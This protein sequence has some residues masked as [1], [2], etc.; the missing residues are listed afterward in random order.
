MPLTAWPLLSPQRCPGRFLPQSL[1]T[2][3]SLCL[4]SY[5]AIISIIHTLASFCPYLKAASLERPWPP[6]QQGSLIK[7]L[8]FLGWPAHPS[9]PKAVPVLKLKIPC[10]GNRLQFS[11]KWNSCSTSSPH[12]SSHRTLLCSYHITYSYLLFVFFLLSESVPW[13]HRVLFTAVFL[14]PRTVPGTQLEFNSDCLAE[15]SKEQPLWF[16]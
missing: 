3:C 9:L 15:I 8:P 14:A 5:S 13:G 2:F 1:C 7:R 12:H 16:I 11:A 6:H 4:G 10:T